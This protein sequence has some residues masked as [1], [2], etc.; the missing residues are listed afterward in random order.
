MITKV[1][2]ENRIAVEK[3]LEEISRALG[4][5]IHNIEEYYQNIVAISALPTANGSPYKYFLMPLD[6]PVF[7][8]DANTR[9]IAVP[10]HFAKNG[11]GVH[12]DHMA[13]VLY[14]KIDRYFDYQDLYKADDIVINW[15]FRPANASRNTEIETHTSYAL[16]PDETYDPGH[17]VFG[18]VI[19]NYVKEKDEEGNPVIAYMTPSRGTL[20]FSISFIKRVENSNKYDYVFNTQT[21]SVNIYDSLVVDNSAK[22]DKINGSALFNRLSNSAYTPEG[23]NPLV[24]PMFLSGKEA[25]SDTGV[26]IFSGLN[27]FANFEFEEKADGKIQEK[28]NLKLTAVAGALD[29]ATGIIYKWSGII[30]Y[31]GDAEQT[32]LEEVPHETTMVKSTAFNDNAF[33]YKAVPG[34]YELITDEESFNDA[35]EQGDLIYDLGDSIQVKKGGTYAVTISSWKAVEG[36]ADKATSPEVKSLSCFIPKAAVPLVSIT[37]EDND[38]EI[39]TAERRLEKLEEKDRKDETVIDGVAT[40]INYK[41]YDQEDSSSAPPSINAIISVDKTKIGVIGFDDNGNRKILSGNDG[42]TE[43]SSLGLI[44]LN[45]VREG[46]DPRDYTDSQEVYVENGIST[47]VQL[48]IAD[49]NNKAGNW[50]VFCQNTRNHTISESDGSNLVYIS[51]VAPSAFPTVTICPIKVVNGVSQ[52]D[53]S[54]PE[55]LINNGQTTEKFNIYNNK[56]YS[57][58]TDIVLHISLPELDVEPEVIKIEA[59]EKAVVR[60]DDTGDVIGIRELNPNEDKDPQDTYPAIYNKENN[61]YV[62]SDIKEGGC[63]VFKVITQYHG[64]QRTTISEPIVLARA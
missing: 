26:K 45:L 46:T 3:R 52:E 42:V 2:E 53:T 54:N 10:Q 6:E 28:E 44:K 4:K 17:I 19:G 36:V 25:S 38:A 32:E 14:F 39:F 59:V 47:A 35:V 63:F 22:L 24:A 37:T 51:K 20:T 60:D 29:D 62:I 1:T 58:S 18:W 61:D 55:T 5:T 30:G 49:A 27:D 11:V 7:E 43:N 48:N 41:Y 9:K 13:E 34:G 23:F 12:G 57:S 8:I 15:Q 33:Q 31:D 56:L 50:Q 21:A 40:F 16:A 64:T